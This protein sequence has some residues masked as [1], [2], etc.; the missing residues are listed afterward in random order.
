MIAKDKVQLVHYLS[1][2]GHA[3]YKFTLKA[4]HVAFFN[5]NADKQVRGRNKYLLMA[6]AI[7]DDITWTY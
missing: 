6:P 5:A 4:L 2:F 7:K 3:K 1:L